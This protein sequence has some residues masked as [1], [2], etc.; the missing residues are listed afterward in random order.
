[1]IPKNLLPE[2]TRYF[3]A[4]GWAVCPALATDRDVFVQTTG[5]LSATRATLLAHMQAEGFD[6]TK[7]GETRYFAGWGYAFVPIA[8]VAKVKVKFAQSIHVLVT[9]ADVA[10]V[11]E[12][13][14]L[15]ICQVAIT[16]TG[17]I[18]KG[19]YWTA[20]NEPICVLKDTPT[21]LARKEKYEARFACG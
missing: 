20:P 10:E 4:G 8:K 15:S 5:D 18:V 13:F 14:D 2:G 3:I 16:H 21:T 1:M 17:G 9:N 19:S 6:L 7:E 12:T 11:L